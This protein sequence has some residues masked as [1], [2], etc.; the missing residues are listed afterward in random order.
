MA[1]KGNRYIKEPGVI[2]LTKEDR[3]GDVLPVLDLKQ[4]VDKTTKRIMYSVHYKK[5]H[6]N[7]NVKKRVQSPSV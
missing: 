7:I 1:R 5:T 4:T 3:E 2:V 6:T